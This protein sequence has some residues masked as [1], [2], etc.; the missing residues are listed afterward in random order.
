MLN[1]WETQGPP[2]DRGPA[3]TERGG[4]RHL[5]YVH[6]IC[7]HQ[8]KY[9]DPWWKALKPHLSDSLANHLESHR[10]EVNWSNIVNDRAVM[11]AASRS[12][13]MRAAQVAAEIKAVLQDRSERAVLEAAPPADRH[14][15]PQSLEQSP[16]P[17]GSIS[18]PGMNCADDFAR[19]LTQ[20]Q[21]RRRIL[22]R[23]LGLV[24]PQLAAGG[25]LDIVSHSWGT[26]VA[27][28]GLRELDDD[29]L[30]GRVLNLFTVGSAPVD[31]A[32][33]T[34]AGRGVSGWPKTKARGA[35]DQPGRPKRRRGRTT[36][37]QPL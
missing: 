22:D 11:E 17:R 6:G 9:S 37:E 4:T 20:S 26:V 31:L 15:A 30:S 21:V 13:D 3:A 25:R 12:E 14:A 7:E 8:P 10:H 32:G 29:L 33:E 2:P 34:H 18:V 1:W 27:Y 19:Y 16:M 28:E 36:N 23:F 24:R 5:V 35:L